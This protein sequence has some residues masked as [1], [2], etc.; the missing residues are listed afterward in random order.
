MTNIA[1][2]LGHQRARFA[3]S[4]GGVAFVVLL[5]LIVRPLRRHPGPAATLSPWPA[6][7]DTAAV[8]GCPGLVVPGRVEFRA[9]RSPLR[10][11]PARPA[12]FRAGKVA[13]SGHLRWCEEAGERRTG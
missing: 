8:L 1:Q 5:I 6:W 2:E 11:V 10:R 13:F 7:R 12:R 9:E 4:T 3:I